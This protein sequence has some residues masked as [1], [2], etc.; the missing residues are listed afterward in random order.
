MH[1]SLQRMVEEG[2]VDSNQSAVQPRLFYCT[3]SDTNMSADGTAKSLSLSVR[4]MRVGRTVD[5]ALREDHELAEEPA[6][7][8]RLA[9]CHRPPTSNYR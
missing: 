2:I 8:G 7:Q 3:W 5:D 1:D 9:F 6:E 4:L